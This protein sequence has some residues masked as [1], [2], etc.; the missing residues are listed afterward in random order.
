MSATDVAIL[1]ALITSLIASS[2]YIGVVNFSYQYGVLPDLTGNSV[3]GQITL[4]PGGIET[5]SQ[6]DYTSNATWSPN[7]TV[8]SGNWIPSPP[9]GM[10]LQAGGL[11]TILLN[12]VAS[13]N[14]V[15]TVQYNVANNTCTPTSCYEWDTVVRYSNGG[16]KTSDLT[17]QLTQNGLE[18][19]QGVSCTEGDVLGCIIQ[20]L[21]G[22][23]VQRIAQVNVPQ[24][25]STGQIVTVL[26]QNEN[27]L[28][29]YN[30]GQRLMYTKVPPVASNIIGTM[31][32]AGIS[33]QEQG[34][35]IR[36]IDANIIEP[37]SP[38]GST[39]TDTGFIGMIFG[40]IS[41]ITNMLNLFLIMAGFVS[42]PLIPGWAFMI[43]IT[44]QVIAILY[45]AARL[46]RGG[47]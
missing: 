1:A 33:A 7:F 12:G 35:T 30:Y 5:T 40:G 29:V 31:N 6:Q 45:I 47:G 11:G 16:L 26:D 46:A 22:S 13:S 24:I 38:S 23:G 44:P 2:A 42:S 37:S 10:I 27:T 9:A 14:N 18:L 4:H 32:Y 15:Y 41:W 19:I 34:F 25:A 8:L 21:P 43:V 17:L 36:S 3:P 39:A 20:G 28:S